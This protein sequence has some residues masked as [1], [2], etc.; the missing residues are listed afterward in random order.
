MGMIKINKGEK[1][2]GVALLKKAVSSIENQRRSINVEASKIGFVGNKQSVYLDLVDALLHMKRHDE[3]FEYVE[4]SK[5][6]ALV[7]ILASKKRFQRAV[8]DNPMVQTLLK[9]LD[10]TEIVDSTKV[11]QLP[12]ED[13]ATTST[14]MR[15]I[16]IRQKLTE[17][18]PNLASLVTVMPPDLNSLLRMIPK[19]ET[20][21]EFYGDDR[22][23]FVF[24]VTPQQIEGLAIEC[25]GLNHKV[26]RFRENIQTPGS[27]LYKAEAKDLYQML[28]IPIVPKIK[29]RKITIVPHGP[30]HYLPFNAIGDASGSLLNYYTI[31]I[32]PSASVLQ[33]LKPD[34]KAPKSALVLGNPDLGNPNFDLPFASQEAKTIARILP[35]AK[36]L[37]R[38]RATETSIK[39]TGGN[40][41]TLHFAS[42]GTFNSD[43][44]LMSGLM[45]AKDNENDGMLTVGELYDLKLNAELVTLSACETALGKVT[46]GDD[47]VG[48][49]RGFLYAGANS[50]ISS[51]W[52]V[53]DRATGELMQAFYLNLKSSNKRDALR[54]A[55]LKLKKD[56]RTTHP[57]YWAAFQLTGAE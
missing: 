10:H 7:D 25:A 56:P 14:S 2:E 20:L 48:F 33:Y 45:L 26:Q 24:I 31:R 11:Y 13:V 19:D 6:R 42:H 22:R 16:A 1:E 27:D 3:A 35:E 36:L 4:R 46:H 37:L 8:D 28:F 32:L 21:I 53:D 44:P 39:K 57:F 23:F 38:G 41:G 5:A 18:D 51:L 50:I 47:V 12:T 54:N 17:T 49:T 9:D 43:A 40:F 55:Q 15:A 52:Q 34:R 29:T 30:L